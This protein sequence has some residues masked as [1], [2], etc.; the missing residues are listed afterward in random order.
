MENLANI[1]SQLSKKANRGILISRSA[2]GFHSL[3]V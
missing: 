1:L 3:D 2:V